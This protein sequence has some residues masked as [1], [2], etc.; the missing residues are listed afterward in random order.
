MGTLA[1]LVAA[2]LVF[3]ISLTSPAQP[4]SQ[5]S[6]QAAAVKRKAD[7][8]QPNAPISVVRVNAPE[9]FGT[10]ISKN[11]DG[12]T[13]Y[14]VDL[15]APVTLA[16]AEIRKIKD[17]YGG[18]NTIQHRHTDRTRGLIVFAVVMAALGGLIGAVA[19]SKD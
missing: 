2:L 15:K 6:K 19:A 12:V 10:F 4:S 14:D 1:R 13:F 3:T 5:P 7:R 16:Y 9:Q 17:G 11:E 8:L 18:Y